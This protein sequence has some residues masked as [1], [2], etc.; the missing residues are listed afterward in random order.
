LTALILAS[1]D[2]PKSPGRLAEGKQLYDSVTF[3]ENG[4]KKR[5]P[6]CPDAFFTIEKN[7]D[8]KTRLSYALEADRGTTTR[9]TFA[10][11]IDAYWRFLEQNR[12]FKAYGV[13]WF[14]VVTFTL[15]DGRAESLSNLASKTL[16][17]KFK[18]YFLFTSRHHMVRTE[19]GL[20]S[21]VY[22]VLR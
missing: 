14:R 6:V 9:R 7:G 22:S 12:Q 5:L 11:K 1:R 21:F 20:R 18:K 8:P 10:D 19:E 4:K 13:K 16:P 2:S 17:A 3:Y 15:T